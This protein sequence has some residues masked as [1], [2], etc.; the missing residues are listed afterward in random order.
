MTTGNFTTHNPQNIRRGFIVLGVAALLVGIATASVLYHSFGVSF[1]ERA[2]YALVGVIFATAGGLLLPGAVLLWQSD[3]PTAA[4]G[5]LLFWLASILP[6]G[7]SGHAGFF[8]LAQSELAAQ[9]LPAQV[10][11]ARLEA[12]Q[13]KLDAVGGAAGVDA[14]SLQPQAD[15]LR[16][17]LRAARDERAACPPGYKKNC[18]DPAEA[19]IS[20][21]QA[22]LQP[23][24]SQLSAH[25]GYIALQT[26]RADTVAALAAASSGAVG[27]GGYHPLFGTL[28]R[29]FSVEPGKLQAAFLGWSA[30]SL[31][32]VAA[33]AFIIAGA[34]ATTP[35][36][37]PKTPA[38][39]SM[40]P[41]GVILPESIPALHTGGLITSDGLALLHTGE[42]VLTVAETADYHAWLSQR[43]N[44]GQR[45]N[46]TANR[47]RETVSPTVNRNGKPLVQRETVIKT[48][49]AVRP[50]A[51]C[52]E[53]FTA[54]RKD[55]KYCGDACRV[56]AWEARTG[57]KLRAGV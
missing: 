5:V 41:A 37:T 12:I 19:K 30:V 35:G 28:A 47:K 34:L 26:Q 15:A 16:Q 55:R 31:E 44:V 36:N 14:E 25:A 43:E 4:A 23:I 38:T 22:E 49:G 11:R 17:A 1:A 54:S 50:C 13:A 48:V 7:L 45:E 42:R 10:E 9:S 27:E 3:K 20:A 18:I 52:G 53:P 24:E 57:A 6:L 39:P 56:K 21:I 33:L 2:V 8:S 32:L 51:C 40:P 29:L 46:V